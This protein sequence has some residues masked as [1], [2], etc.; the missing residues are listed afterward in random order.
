MTSLVP[1]RFEQL[2]QRFNKICYINEE[3]SL[4]NIN[5]IGVNF[6]PSRL[7]ETIGEFLE[8]VIYI[9]LRSLEK[10]KKYDSKTYD[11]HI[12]LENCGPVNFN[13]RMCKY[14]Y[15][16]VSKLFEDTARKIFVYTNSK[17]AYMAFKLT[18]H[19][20]ERETIEKLQFIKN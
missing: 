20:L 7:R 4:V 12:H 2:N 9:S 5:I 3:N 11:I 8:F 1:T 13:I 16:E 17:F 15:V 19:F 18:K 6:Y 14:I 10:A